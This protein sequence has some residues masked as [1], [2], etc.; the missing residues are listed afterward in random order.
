MC[1]Q[2]VRVCVFVWH[3]CT[4]GVRAG[5]CVSSSAAVHLCLDMGSLTELEAEAV[6]LS[7]WLTGEQV[8]RLLP[9]PSHCWGYR[10]T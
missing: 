3:M 10:H 9:L 2:R 1:V 4:V 6:T 5:S 8:I 7:A